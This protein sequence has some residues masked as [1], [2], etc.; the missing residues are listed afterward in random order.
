[1]KKTLIIL[2]ILALILVSAKPEPVDTARLTIINKSG[3]KIALRLQSKDEDLRVYY[4]PVP[5][6]DRDRPVYQ[7]Y[8]VEKDEYYMQLVYIQTWD[9]VYGFKCQTPPPSNLIL[10][11][12]LRIVFIECG[13]INARAGEPSM[14]KYSPP[15]SRT[16]GNPLSG[17]C[18][19]RAPHYKLIKCYRFWRS[20]YI[21]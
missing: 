7:S 21:Y 6:G 10:F 9:P 2:S 16:G 19:S 18:M 15:P 5:M 13:M 20:R 3:M 14:H 12:N 4:L 17:V 8:D 11:R 1:M